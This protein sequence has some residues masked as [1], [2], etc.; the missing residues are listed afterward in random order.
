MTTPPQ[1]RRE[2]SPATT[3]TAA[4]FE[5]PKNKSPSS[6][7]CRKCAANKANFFCAPRSLQSP[8][9][10]VVPLSVGIA[11]FVKNGMFGKW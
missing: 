10:V 7:R 11:T 9:E 5:V 6:F 1:Q 3:M 2:D 8:V 4:F